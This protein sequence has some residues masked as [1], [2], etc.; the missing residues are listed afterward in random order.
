MLRRILR[1]LGQ[2]PKHFIDAGER[3]QGVRRMKLLL[4]RASVTLSG[5][6]NQSPAPPPRPLS[7]Q[8][9]LC[10]I[11]DLLAIS[12][13]AD[14]EA[15]ITQFSQ[16]TESFRALIRRCL[17]PRRLP[18]RLQMG[19]RQSGDYLGVGWR[20]PE[21]R[22]RRR[23]RYYCRRATCYIQ[24]RRS[25]RILVITAGGIPKGFSKTMAGAILVNGRKLGDL[26][27][28]PGLWES[29]E[30]PLEP[31]EGEN[32]AEALEIEL[33]A[34]EKWTH[35]RYLQNGDER[36]LSMGVEVIQCR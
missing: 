19:S 6:R 28:Q 24:R 13:D 3:L 10:R 7:P 16:K 27:A 23:F 5:Q 35:H 26:K 21:Q 22:G 33:Q 2:D 12:S 32:A 25:D 29:F 30:F 4:A 36:E 17:D 9:E 8:D 1:L 18:E 15:E 11:D 34:P 31:F 20:L 14:P